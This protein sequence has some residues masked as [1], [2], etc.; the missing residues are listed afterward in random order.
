M[1]LGLKG[2]STEHSARTFFN[3]LCEAQMISVF[4]EFKLKTSTIWMLMNKDSVLMMM[5]GIM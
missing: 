3:H 2:A 5:A 4:P 1:R